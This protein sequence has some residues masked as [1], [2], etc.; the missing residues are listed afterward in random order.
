MELAN[1]RSRRMSIGKCRTAGR[2]IVAGRIGQLD[3]MRQCG[4]PTSLWIIGR[5][6]DEKQASLVAADDAVHEER[7]AVRQ[8]HRKGQEY[9]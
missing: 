8:E 9:R 7:F 4:G 2:A 5:G 6:F 1:Q 3:W